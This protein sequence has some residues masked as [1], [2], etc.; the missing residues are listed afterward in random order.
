[1]VVSRDFSIVEAHDISED[2][3]EKLRTKY[4]RDT[5]ITKHIEPSMEGSK[6]DGTDGESGEGQN[7][8]V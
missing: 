7:P 1:M 6:A 4:G 8:Q 5:H 3:E 2:L